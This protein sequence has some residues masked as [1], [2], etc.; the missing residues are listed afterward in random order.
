MRVY[1]CRTLLGCMMSP[2]LSLCVC[3]PYLAGPHDEPVVGFVS[4]C[5][6]LCMCVCVCGYLAGPHD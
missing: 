5:V 2:W 1:A 6:C 4:V 3:V